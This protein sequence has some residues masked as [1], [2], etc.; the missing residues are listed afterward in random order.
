MCIAGKMLLWY[1]QDNVNQAG[2]A[3]LQGKVNQF[4]CGLSTLT[5]SLSP[6][7]TSVLYSFSFI[8]SFSSIYF[9]FLFLFQLPSLPLSPCPSCFQPLPHLF[10]S[11]PYPFCLV[12]TPH[13]KMKIFLLSPG[14]SLLQ[15]YIPWNWFYRQCKKSTSPT[16]QIQV[17]KQTNLEGIL[18]CTAVQ[19]GIVKWYK[20]L[21]LKQ[22]LKLKFLQIQISFIYLLF[23]LGFCGEPGA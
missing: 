18:K 9:P 15:Q 16:E 20:C 7:V 6:S 3:P 21:L 12:R 10:Q 8:F 17:F 14:I 4:Q 11:P 5:S 19:C 23:T 13:R 22:Q 2:T 1:L